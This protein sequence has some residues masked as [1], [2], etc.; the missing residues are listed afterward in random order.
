M[1]RQ[2]KEAQFQLLHISV[3]REYI[4]IDLGMTQV[5]DRERLIDDFVLLTFL[6]G[7]DFLPHLPTLDIS[8]HAFDVVFTAYRTVLT[9]ANSNAKDQYLVKHG[10]IADFQLLEKLFAIIGRY[11]ML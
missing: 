1:M 9:E 4:E 2:T 8:E 6:V 3:L 5:L 11:V 10:E 7:N